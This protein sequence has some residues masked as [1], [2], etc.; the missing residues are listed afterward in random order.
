MKQHKSRDCA[1]ALRVSY[2]LKEILA[3]PKICPRMCKKHKIR[4]FSVWGNSTLL[5]QAVEREKY[6]ELDYKPSLPATKRWERG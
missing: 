4:I 3:P 5:C 1:H 2:L 6:R